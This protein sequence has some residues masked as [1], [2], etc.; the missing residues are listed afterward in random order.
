MPEGSASFDSTSSDGVTVLNLSQLTSKA[1][2][3]PRLESELARECALQ[4]AL[5][6]VM[7]ESPEPSDGNTEI[8]L[9][10]DLARDA[11]KQVIIDEARA[12]EE[13][14]VAAIDP[15]GEAQ[16]AADA[17]VEAIARMTAGLSQPPTLLSKPKPNLCAVADK[18][19]GYSS[20]A[21]ARK[22]VL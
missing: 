1:I 13:A 8:F 4:M 19:A 7:Y 15:N 6:E 17:M 3:Q 9:G 14:R 11:A 18:G 10:S 12:A 5:D 16:R 22:L 21:S 20:P 2:P